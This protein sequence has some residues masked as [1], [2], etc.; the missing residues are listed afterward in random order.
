MRR[1]IALISAV[2]TVFSLVIL[3]SVVYAYGAQA[4]APKSNVQAVAPAPAMQNISAPAP[5]AVADLSPQAAAAVA[6]TFLNQTDAYSVEL[7]DYQGTQCYKVTFTSG[8]LVY[9]SMTGQILGVVPPSQVAS[10]VNSWA[11]RGG[12][13]HRPKAP[14][15][16]GGHDDGGSEPPDSGG[17]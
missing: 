15:D 17:G 12:G 7:A 2:V 14:G 10:S 5:A 13:G 3:A 6:S 16:D 4:A 1:G 9:V 8:S 11:A